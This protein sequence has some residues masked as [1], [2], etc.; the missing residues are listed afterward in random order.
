MLVGLGYTVLTQFW[1]LLLG[2]SL[3]TAARYESGEGEPNAMA[4][5]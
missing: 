4:E 2:R 1:S 5:Q 3:K